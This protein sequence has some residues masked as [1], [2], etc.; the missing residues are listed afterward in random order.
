M[1]EELAKME[2]EKVSSNTGIDKIIL[3][4]E[5]YDLSGADIMKITNGKTRIIKYEDLKLYDSLEQLFNPYGCFIMLYQTSEKIGHWVALIDRG[6]REL[7]FY[8]PYGF[9]PDEE[10]N[11]NNDYHLRIHGGIITPH[12]SALIESGFWKVKY[13]N[14]QL[15]K[16]LE[17]VNT[18]GRY[19]A[20]RIKFK[21]ASL[22]KFNNL[23]T[24]NKC[25]NSD[26]WVSALTLLC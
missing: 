26:F 13:N 9:E 11:F 8:D 7:E 16:Y 18:C 1:T 17:D 2:V 15:Q 14:K 20:L 25:Y 3:D 22:E 6:N 23:L 21:D 12:L 19:C 5:K 4:A 24:K 10:L